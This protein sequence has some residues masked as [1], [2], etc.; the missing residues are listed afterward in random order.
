MTHSVERPVLH[1]GSGRD[2]TVRGTEPCVGLCADSE[3]HAW[4]S[5]SL[6]LYLSLSFLLAL[7]PSVSQNKS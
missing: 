2:L 7:P 4:V 1:F 5:F 3:E 6:S